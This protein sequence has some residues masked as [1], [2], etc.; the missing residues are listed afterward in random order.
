MLA[1]PN[2]KRLS[3]VYLGLMDMQ[4]LKRRRK[5]PLRRR[6]RARENDVLRRELSDL[7]ES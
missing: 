2:T 6:N 5:A 7:R 3:R 1:W 4:E